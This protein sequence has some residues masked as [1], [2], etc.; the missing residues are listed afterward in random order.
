MEHER[1][2]DVVRQVTEHAQR[3]TQL[4]GQLAKVHGHGV[5]LINGQLRPQ[6]RVSLQTRREIAVELDNGHFVKTF[7]NRLG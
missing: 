2:G 1:R 7:A 6:E 3:L 4:L 5:L